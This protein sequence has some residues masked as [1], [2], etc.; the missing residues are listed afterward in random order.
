[1]T[2][3]SGLY[4]ISTPIGNI[5]DVTLRAIDIL[6]NCDYIVCEDTRISNKLLA[7]HDIKKTMIVYN[8]RSDDKTRAFLLEKITSGHSLALISDAGTPLISDPG[9]KLVREF[10]KLG[11]F[12]DSIPGPCSLISALTLSGL[13][14]DRF[15][16]EGFLPKTLSQKTKIFQQYKQ[17][18]FD[19]TLIFFETSNRLMETLKSALDVFGDLEACVARELTKIYQEAITKKISELIKYYESS[20]L[21]GEIVLIISCKK[22]ENI[23][24]EEL[25]AEIIAFIENKISAR[26]IT[27]IMHQKYKQYM[28]KNIIYARVNLLTK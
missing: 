22:R 27:N 7:K 26:D 2:L 4:I 5:N 16:F 10:K 17:L 3:K 8:D 6:K 9:Y 25:D 12:I 11:V 1:M 15:L 23:E 24:I 19:T 21:K 14:T 13:P 20:T 18:P 28:S